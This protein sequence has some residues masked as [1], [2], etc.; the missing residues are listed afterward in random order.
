[1]T[2]ATKNQAGSALWTGNTHADMPGIEER[3][4]F[5]LK[6]LNGV[7]HH[8]DAVKDQYKLPESLIKQV[9]KA[10]GYAETL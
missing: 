5:I 7:L 1:M 6:T 2:Q 4:A 8:S 9:C 10:I 3:Y